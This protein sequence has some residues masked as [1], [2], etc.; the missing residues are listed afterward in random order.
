M[1]RGP[2]FTARWSEGAWAELKIIE[3]FNAV[4]G[5]YAAQ[6]GITDGTAFYSPTKMAARGLPVQNLYGKRPDILVY[7]INDLSPLE[8]GLAGQLPSLPDG[9]VDH[10][11]RKA[12]MAIESE[13]SPYMYQHRLQSYG[14][15]LS[16]TIKDEDLQ[17]L[18][19]W[20]TNFPVPLHIAQVYLDSSYILP[21]ATLVRGI[22]DGSI[23][24]QIE[25]N[26]NK[27]VYYPKMSVGVPMANFVELP[28]T[29]ADTVLD[30][31]GKY[32]A[33]RL[34]TGG[35]LELT[36]EVRNLLGP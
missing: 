34:V 15:E 32:T 22:N 20:Q 31:Y 8:Y 26:Y 33:F 36:P 6:F 23:K 13:F 27:P 1:A 28:Q 30:E 4:P 16:F 24:K 19:S 29:S 11:V 9:E 12:I 7:R 25:R 17:P 2:D 5:I 21:F 18:L 3:A 10:V 35:K 14:K